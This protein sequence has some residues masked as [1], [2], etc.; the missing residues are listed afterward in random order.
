MNSTALGRRFGLAQ[1]VE[2]W[3]LTTLRDKLIKIGK[4]VVSHARY[5]V[6]QPVGVPRELFMVALER[7]HG[8]PLAPT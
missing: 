8:L 5:V 3:S 7:I 4:R 2:Q 6:F 1:S